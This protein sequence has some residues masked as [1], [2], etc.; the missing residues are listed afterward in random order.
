VVLLLAL[1]LFVVLEVLTARGRR[2]E[3]PKD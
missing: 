2:P 1:T 3:G